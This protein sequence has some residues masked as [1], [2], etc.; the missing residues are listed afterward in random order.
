MQIVRLESFIIKHKLIN[1]S[2]YGF[3][4]NMS[5]CHTLIYLTDGITQ[6]LDAKQYAVGIFIDLKGT[7]RSQSQSLLCKTN[8]IS[9]YPWCGI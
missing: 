6:S 1:L 4:Q 2:Q 7:Q 3:K 5:T 8:G 9:C